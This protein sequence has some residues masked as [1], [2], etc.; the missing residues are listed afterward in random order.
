LRNFFC[1]PPAKIVR[2]DFVHLLSIFV[3][4]HISSLP[5]IEDY[6]H[7]VLQCL[8]LLME[9]HT[10]KCKQWG[11][12]I[13]KHNVRWHH[14]SQLKASTICSFRKTTM[15]VNKTHQLIPGISTALLGVMEPHCLNANIYSYLETSGGQISNIYLNVLHFFNTGIN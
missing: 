2:G 12:I 7:S 4:F 1:S 11:G 15:H 10:L 9:Q 6:I 8:A 5:F 13:C 14:E 3:Y